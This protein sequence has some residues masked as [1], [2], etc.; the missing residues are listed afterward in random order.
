MK[1]AILIAICIIV[2]ITLLSDF[3][4]AARKKKKKWVK[5]KYGIKALL[6]LGKDR[7]K[8][9]REYNIETMNYEKALK[10]VNKNTLKEGTPAKDVQSARRV[11]PC[12][13]PG[14]GKD[15]RSRGAF[16]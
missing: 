12:R 3:S 13:R 14:G 1:K 7:D 16:W 4:S 10:A 2:S 5:S 8:M 9:V 6:Q 15:Y 11:D